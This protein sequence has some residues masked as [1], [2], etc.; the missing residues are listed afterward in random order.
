MHQPIRILYVNG[1]SLD[2]GGISSYMFN[3]CDRFDP[4]LVQVDFLVHGMAEGAREK[5]AVAAGHKV[6]HVPGKREDYPGN[7]QGIRT[8]L[9]QGKYDIVHS[10]MDAMNS[11]ISKIAKSCGVS[12][13]ISHCHNTQ[14]LTTNPLRVLLH[15]KARLEIPRV[16]THL[17]ACSEDAGA[18]F[19]GKKRVASGEVRIVKNAINL[20]KYRFSPTDRARI[21]TEFGLSEAYIIVH[22]GRFDYQK[23]Q[24]FLLDAFSK[25]AA[26]DS[27]AHLL[28]VGDGQDRKML[29]EQIRQ[30]ALQPRVTL[31]GYRE[32]VPALLSASDLFVLPSR[33]E[34]LGIVLIEAQRNGL[35]CI[36][37]DRVPTET[38]I[39][40]CNYLPIDDPAVWAAAM[41]KTPDRTSRTVDA[42]AFA[43]HG[44]DI[45]T[46][47]KKLQSFYLE[48]VR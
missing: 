35:C 36:A 19:Y 30:L 48:C 2:Y 5:E 40:D 33:F 3:Y 28:L 38:R 11:Y 14:F 16:A 47:A 31:C 23:N 45:E 25:L 4:S 32:D 17:L 12:I 24:T 26:V 20:P 29:E 15:R 44:Y 10:H 6:F 43:A 41:Q 39:V 7:I 37:S 13:R 1:G 9:Q 42:S 18:F 34:G 46:E 8:V 27:A 21:R 22:I